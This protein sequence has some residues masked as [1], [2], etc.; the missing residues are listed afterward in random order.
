MIKTLWFIAAVFA[1]TAVAA[2]PALHPQ[3]EIFRPFL[4]SHWEGDLTQPGKE[5]KLI[6]RSIWSRALNGQA[7]KTVHSINDGEYGGETMIFWDQKQKKIAYYY[8]TTAG[9]YTHGTM[10]YNPD[11]KSIEALEKVENNAQGIT[12]VRSHSVLEPTG[13]LQISS[14]YLQ[15]GEWVKGH[16]ATYKQ[17]PKTEVVFH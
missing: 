7:I 2:P 1:C 8:F 14:E 4:D 10:T 17:V 11:T 9:F 5:K 15:N 3:L 6:D 12:Q 16:S 13:I